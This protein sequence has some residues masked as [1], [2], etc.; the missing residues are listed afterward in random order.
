MLA[1]NLF[2]GNVTPSSVA[3]P[4]HQREANPR[5][6]PSPEPETHPRGQLQRLVTLIP[7]YLSFSKYFSL[8][9]LQVLLSLHERAPAVSSSCG[10]S[11]FFDTV[12][13]QFQII[14][15][16]PFGRCQLCNVAVAQLAS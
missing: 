2:L 9:Q 12:R 15:R 7:L 16:E 14:A 4:N 8:S 10:T 5:G 13:C 6:L 3:P 11:P 1:T